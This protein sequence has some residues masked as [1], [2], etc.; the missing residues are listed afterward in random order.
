MNALEQESGI[1]GIQDAMSPARHSGNGGTGTDTY[2][3]L[4]DV[5]T[6]GVLQEMFGMFM[7][8]KKW[9]QHYH[10]QVWREKTR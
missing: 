2:L 1:E 3:Q 8:M 10:L 9:I 4:Q 7:F 5:I 6:S